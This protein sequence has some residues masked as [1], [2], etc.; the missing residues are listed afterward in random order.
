MLYKFKRLLLEKQREEKFR[1][2]LYKESFL[3]PKALALGGF[4]GTEE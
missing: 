3:K 2:F 4:M 1:D